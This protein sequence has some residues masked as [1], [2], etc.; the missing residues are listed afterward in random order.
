[1]GLELAQCEPAVEI[2]RVADGA[3]AAHAAKHT[4]AMCNA[5]LGPADLFGPDRHPPVLG[6]LELDPS[7]AALETVVHVR[8]AAA[9]DAARLHRHEIE[10]RQIGAEQMTQST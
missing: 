10:P 4:P 5:P 6:E 8:D 2:E 7:L 1:M 3:G 9:D